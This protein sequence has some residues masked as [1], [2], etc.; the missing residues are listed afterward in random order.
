[1]D[2]LYGLLEKLAVF[3]PAES[4]FERGFQTALLLAAMV[5]FLLLIICLIL[6]LIFRKPAVPGVTLERE[7]GNIFIARNAIYTAVCRLESDFPELEILK[8]VLQRG[9]RKDL[10]L[11]VTVMFDENGSAFDEL[12]GTFK[13]RV[14][15]MLSKS[16]GIDS[17]KTVSVNL[18]KIPPERHEADNDTPDTPVINNAFIS[19]V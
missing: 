4:E 14:F 12:A 17:I 8:V 19:G 15:D 3:I 9:A 7:D 6:K 10:A 11:S 1:M 16:F 2:Y 18:S 13:Q 5:F